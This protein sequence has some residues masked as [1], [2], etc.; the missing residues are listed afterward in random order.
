MEQLGKEIAEVGLD[1]RVRGPETVSIHAVP[2]L[3]QRGSP[4]RLLRDLLSEVSR[5]AAA[6]SPTPS[7]RARDHGVPRLDPRGRHA[8]ADRS[9][10]AAH[11]ARSRRIS[12]DIA[13]TGR[14]IVTAL[15][16]AELERKVGR[17]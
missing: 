14:P 7:I 13:R 4:E 5:R 12:P 1:V 2:K 15:S 8:L 9:E 10:G 16:W 11:G 3:L 17:R 6:D